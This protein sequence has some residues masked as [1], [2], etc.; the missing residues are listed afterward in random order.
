MDRGSV[1]YVNRNA[2]TVNDATASPLRSDARAW[3]YA[4]LAV[5]AVGWGAQEF[6]PLLLFYQ[7]H[8]HLSATMLQATFV[9]YVIGLIPGLLLGGPFSDRYGRRRVMAPTMVATA[10]ASV[11]MILGTAG[12][13]WV[14]AG[15]LLAGI[16]SGAGFSSGAAWIKELSVAGPDAAVNPGPRRLTVAMGVGFCLGPLVSGVLAQ[17]VPAPG[18]VPYLPHLVLSA[19]AFAAV[20]RTPETLVPDSGASL[21]RNLHIGEVRGRRFR[22]VVAPLAPWVFIV[23]AIA[24]GYLPTLV[25][26]HITDYKLIFSAAVVVANAGAGVSVQPLARRVNR[27]DR[28]LLLVTGLGICVVGLLIAALAAGLV[29]PPLVLLASFLLG[30]GYGCAQVYGLLEVQRLARP[31]HLAGLTAIYQALTYIGFAASYPLAALQQFAAAWVLLV[32]VAGLA[33]LT[34]LWTARAAVTTAPG[35]VAVPPIATE[36]HDQ[37]V[38][39]AVR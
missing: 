25:K 32:V 29:S 35:P 23:V 22:T 8:L 9:P 21:L 3:L 17:W 27:P 36:Q 26:S 33:L 18:V 2:H 12:I 4:G 31:D 38:D 6:T 24:I 34:L 11:L 19:L 14:M 28:P 20:L 37:P 7:S 16:A 39:P 30:A 10:L 13:G 5:A 1:V 15:R